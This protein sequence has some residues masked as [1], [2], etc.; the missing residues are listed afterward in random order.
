MK[1]FFRAFL[2]FILI[3]FS[4]ASVHAATF[5]VA[6]DGNDA[7]PGTL[8]QPLLTFQAGLNKLSV[9]GDILYIRAGTYNVG[10]TFWNDKTG[11]AAQNFVIS[12]YE[13]ERPI[14]DGSALVP[15]SV[16]SA[17]DRLWYGFINFRNISYVLIK[18]LEIK[19]S[20][21]RVIYVADSHHVTFQNIWIHDTALSAIEAQSSNDIIIEN[22]RLWMNNKVN[23]Y[24]SSWYR[25]QNWMGSIAVRGPYPS[26]N[27]NDAGYVDSDYPYSTNITIRNNQIFQS[28][29]EGINIHGRT[30]NTVIEDNTIYDCW[31]ACIYFLNSKDVLIQRNLVYHTNDPRFQRARNGAIGDPN[32][33]IGTMKE[34]AP[35]VYGELRNI[36]IINNLVKGF[37]NNFCFWENSVYGTPGFMQDTLIAHNTFLDAHSNLGTP[38]SIAIANGP[39]V[40]TRFENNII[41]QSNSTTGFGSTDSRVAFSNNVWSSQP[42]NA[43]QRGVDDIYADPLLARTGTLA[44]G[45]L[46]SSYF[47]ITSGSPAIG[48]AKTSNPVIMEDFFRAIRTTPDIGAHEFGSSTPNSPSP[49]IQSAPSPTSVIPGVPTIVPSGSPTTTPT[50]TTLPT[51]SP[52]ITSYKTGDLNHDGKVENQDVGLLISVYL[53]PVST[54]PDADLNHDGKINAIDYAMLVELVGT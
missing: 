43:N 14:L 17:V 46:T 5:Y 52:T 37:K 21:T 49:T 12:G 3:L 23:D 45:Q 53:R 30:S 31:S 1:I 50:P 32:V 7:N 47:R 27:P 36:T 4:T 10:R 39:H 33:G 24:R 22:S 35:T 18:N 9:A 44:A 25:D 51:T 42:A 48:K 34:G 15:A 28:Y 29:G 26:K 54:L 8:A 19:N 6:T 20:E 2:V 11:T 40:N 41:A 16:T 38:T 13:N